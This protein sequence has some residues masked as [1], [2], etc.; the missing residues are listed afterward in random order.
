MKSAIAPIASI[1]GIILI[2]ISFMWTK[3][4]PPILTDKE[5]EE[6]S[7]AV[8]T[9][10]LVLQNKASEADMEKSAIVANEKKAKL[11]AGIQR[12]K[13]GV[14]LFRAVGVVV[15]LTGGGFYLWIKSQED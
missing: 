4:Q 6:Y 1:V 5:L 13:M 8:G 10:E 9:R 2:G 3:I 12:Q 11:E 14:I 7:N 15:A